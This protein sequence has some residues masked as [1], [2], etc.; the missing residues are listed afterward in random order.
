MRC[1]ALCI[2]LYSHI[3]IKINLRRN[4]D[5]T[6]KATPGFGMVKIL[7]SSAINLL[8]RHPNFVQLCHF[9]TSSKI[10]AAVFNDGTLLCLEGMLTELGLN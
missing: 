5:R 9:A 6:W 3:Q 4:G 8:L 2:S 1:V 7:C 10:H